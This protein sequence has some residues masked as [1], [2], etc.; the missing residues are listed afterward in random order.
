M[1]LSSDAVV[2]TVVNAIA[3]VVIVVSVIDYEDSNYYYQGIIAG[4]II[5]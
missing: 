2:V 4:Y 3:F 1:L 5:G